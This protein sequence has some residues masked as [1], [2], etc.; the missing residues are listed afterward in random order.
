MD[1]GRPLSYLVL[2]DIF[3]IYPGTASSATVTTTA[4]SASATTPPSAFDSQLCRLA[5]SRQN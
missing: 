2:G 3:C 4:A 5:L 1:Q